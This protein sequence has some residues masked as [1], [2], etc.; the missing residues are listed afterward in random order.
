[1]NRHHTI[2]HF[3]PVAEPLPPHSR[4]MRAT[5]GRARLIDGADGLRMGMLL[6]NDLLAAVAQLFFIPLD[7]F[8][9]TL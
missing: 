2:V 3:T 9:K 6:G 1:M 8:E 5:F 7:G 4:R